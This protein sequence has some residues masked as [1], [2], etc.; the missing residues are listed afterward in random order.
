MGSDIVGTRWEEC[1][2]DARRVFP[3]HHEKI[4]KLDFV[5]VL[6]EEEM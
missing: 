2:L 3:Y 1:S 4:N 6:D 5:D